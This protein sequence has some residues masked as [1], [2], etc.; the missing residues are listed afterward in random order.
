MPTVEMVIVLV[1]PLAIQMEHFG[2]L[3]VDFGSDILTDIVVKRMTHKDV[4]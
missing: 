4:S 1:A 2:N 3:G